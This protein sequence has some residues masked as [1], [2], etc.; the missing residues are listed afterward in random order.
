M[1]YISKY[2]KTTPTKSKAELIAEN[3]LRQ[4]Y[5]KEEQKKQEEPVE[6]KGGFSEFYGKYLSSPLQTA[7]AVANPVALWV[8]KA[9]GL[10]DKAED[11][12]RDIPVVN[13]IYS[14]I[15]DT[16][17][18]LFGG[19]LSSVE[20]IVDIGAGV[21]GGVGGAFSPEFQKKVKD[22]IATDFVGESVYAQNA[23]QNQASLINKLP[24]QGQNI[25]RG[26]AQGVGQVLPSVFTAGAAGAA[27][28][29]AKLAQGIGTATF[30]AGAAGKG[31]EEAFQEGAGYGQGLM[32][33]TAVGIVEGAIEKLTGGVAPKVFGKGLINKVV[34]KAI[35][36]NLGKIALNALGEGF[37]EALS[38]AI[39]PLL[40]RITYDKDAPLATKEQMLESAVIGA[41]TSIVSGATINR[42]DPVVEQAQELQKIN[43][44]ARE[45]WAEGKTDLTQYET[46]RTEAVAKYNKHSQEQITSAPYQYNEAVS[47][48][49]ENL[50]YQPTTQQ[51]TAEQQEA[52]KLFTQLSK[53]KG[54][55]FSDM[56]DGVNGAY[57]D[58]V[59]YINTKANAAQE[60][61]KHEL[62]HSAEGTKAYNKFA[63]YVLNTLADNSELAQNIKG[64]TLLESIKRTSE[65][66]Q[67]VMDGKG[68]TQQQREVLTEVVAQYSEKLLTDKT[69][70]ANLVRQDKSIAQKI[71][72][73]IR[74]KIAV[75]KGKTKAE[76][77]TIAFLRKAERLYVEALGET[78]QAKETKYS[79]SDKEKAEEHRQKAIEEFG[80]TP[81]FYDAGY[82]LPDG[83]MLNLSGE[84]G[85]H[86]GSRGEDHR[87]I[88]SIFEEG[89]LKGEY[90]S[91]GMVQFMN[92]GN[93]RIMPETPGI[94]ISLEV[95]PTIDQ[96]T[97]IQKFISD[98]GF[99][100]RYFNV[101]FSSKN[102]DNVDSIEYDGNVRASKVI[103]DIKAYFKTGKIPQQSEV[104]KFRYSLS[105]TDSQGR[106]LT[107][108]QQEFFKD[109]K[110]R[111]GNKLQTVWHFT[112]KGNDFTVFK[113]NALGLIFVSELPSAV[114][115]MNYNTSDQNTSDIKKI[116]N[117]ED[118]Y[119]EPRFELYGEDI[120]DILEDNVKE[121]FELLGNKVTPYYLNSKKP[122]MKFES[123]SEFADFMRFLVDQS[124][125]R[126]TLRTYNIST[127]D[128]DNVKSMTEED[129]LNT[130]DDLY[131]NLNGGQYDYR[132]T[133]P[134]VEW[135]KSK[136]YDAFL[137]YEDGYENSNYAFF[138]PNQ[139]KRVD[140]LNPTANEDIRY[141]LDKKY[142]KQDAEQVAEKAVDVIKIPQAFGIKDSKALKELIYKGLNQNQ[143]QQ[144]KVAFEVA[145]YI[146]EN[147][148]VFDGKEELLKNYDVNLKK[149]RSDIA[150]E[151]L[152]GYDKTGK[153]TSGWTAVQKLRQRIEDLKTQI[154]GVRDY[155]E[156][157][158]KLKNTVDLVANIGKFTPANTQ[159]ATSV[160][161]FIKAFTKIKTYYGN[162]SK[163]GRDIIRAYKGFYPELSG[164][165]ELE[166]DPIYIKISEISDGTGK[167]TLDELQ[168]VNTIL[169][170][171][172]ND[173]KN[174]QNVW[175]GEKKSTETDFAQEGIAD[176][177]ALQKESGSIFNRVIG[178]GVN[179]YNMWVMS[180]DVVFENYSSSAEGF[181][182]KAYQELF[183][184]AT[185]KQAAKQHEFSEIFKGFYQKNKKEV[186]TWRDKT[187]N[188][189]KNKIS[190]ETALSLY[191]T[192]QQEAG[193]RDLESGII[194]ISDPKAST[195]AKAMEKAKD[196]TFDITDLDG[197]YD[198]FNDAMKEY[199]RLGD[200]K[201]LNGAAQKTFA[202]T[203]EK[204][205]GVH[206]QLVKNYF[207]LRASSDQLYKSLDERAGD[208]TGLLT[209]VPSFTK[210]RKPNAKVKL[211]IEPYTDVISRHYRQL[212]HFAGW[213][214][215]LNTFNRVYNKSINGQSLR[216][217]LRKIDPNLE[218]Y[219]ETY[220]AD[221]Q[222]KR[223][224]LTGFDK[225]VSKIRGWGARAT[226]AFNPKVYL[227]QTVS[228]FAAHSM[229]ISY[230]DILKGG[231][232]AI[233]AKQSD[234]ELMYKYAPL[235]WARQ[236]EGYNIDVGLLKENQNIFGRI[237]KL[238][239][240]SL[241]LISKMDNRVI[242][243]VWQACLEHTKKDYTL[244]SDEHYK[245]AGKLLESTMIRT[246]ANYHPTFRAAAL[247][248]RN[249][250]AQFSTM[251]IS[252]PLKQ[253]GQMVAAVRAIQKAK[254]AQKNAK[255]ESERTKATQQLKD[256]SSRARHAATAL[257]VQA[258]LIVM[259]N[260]LFRKFLGKDDEEFLK[261][262]GNDFADNFIGMFPV[263]RDLYGLYQG[264]DLSNMYYTGLT[265]IFNAFDGLLDMG[266]NP[267]KALRGF[268]LGMSQFF[269]M[270]LKNVERY[271][272]AL[273]DKFNPDTSYKYNDIF[274]K[275]S[276]SKDLKKAIEK[277]DDKK[278]D[279]IIELM[280]NDKGLGTD[281]KTR[282]ELI[283][284]YASGENVLPT[285]ISDTVNG[286][287][288]TPSQK[289]QI[290]DIYSK[291][292]ITKL[293]SMSEYTKMTAAQ[294]AKAIRTIYSLQKD[295]A[296]ARV[297]GIEMSSRAL[298]TE[299]VDPS[300]IAYVLAMISNMGDNKKVK[301]QQLINRLNIP[302][303]Q[304][305]ML[306]GLAGYKNKNGANIVKALINKLDLS[307]AE[308]EK[309][310]Q[311]SGY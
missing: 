166:T 264:Y 30:M 284:L 146:I 305:Y 26:V 128:I 215:P 172:R 208:M 65:L 299:A 17:A 258:V 182:N 259:I 262:V 129:I 291:A 185:R 307:K 27:G 158:S 20:G 286:Q 282:A 50:V 246:Q 3:R 33:G 212:A 255:T 82:I 119:A 90:Q 287:E 265:N 184:E 175:W 5:K 45:A 190:V 67:K 219:I 275:Q 28:A 46:R 127:N 225:L 253:Y 111:S 123:D 44:E 41:L 240:A 227:N 112:K 37:E 161:A 220:I 309:L 207:P 97:I 191:A 285:A 201:F 156:A 229:G 114:L 278:A 178:R 11:K 297:L 245:A 270:P 138:N 78:A 200:K 303:T 243:G 159:L 107:K 24:Q 249:A 199:L 83:E 140:N 234:F 168:A 8:G 38:E 144:S 279:T 101:D 18:N 16:Q 236:Q 198:Q 214:V 35:K 231:T 126:E 205:Y 288:L 68:L 108:E 186:E 142:T 304:K 230:F 74:D 77:D 84:K 124:L 196:I 268:A 1:A 251:F 94:D 302:A 195:L 71:L 40:K 66:Y 15:G 150:R 12:I 25:V 261:S 155:H 218:N 48:G 14:T 42:V 135:V 257:S 206:A 148:V 149:V 145:D 34:G 263:V 289:K 308:K 235:T 39:N 216:A 63:K 310:Y 130:F 306:M 210:S 232:R 85:K 180:P 164:E 49:V 10:L 106:K 292:D 177:Q 19:T 211:V 120:T 301:I 87:I 113:P 248:E 110:I 23:I 174:Y 52:K 163:N 197:L 217:E 269:G 115:S 60:I 76:K 189:G 271:T 80:Y 132:E 204:R 266:E 203:Y 51:L 152:Q 7:L 165:I 137:V 53:D 179:K 241:A 293:I 276:Y 272:V 267:A 242:M 147:T 131:Y 4:Q 2:K 134:F 9:T 121:E 92:E 233:T 300:L 187:V 295:K 21:V 6:S 57:K 13:D 228:L 96:Y 202:E 141:S 260:Q 280:L 169:S 73:W 29:S 224:T 109:S 226:L 277:G 86:F 56:E 59:V 55:V 254:Q 117:P 105:D 81:Y 273:I 170:K 116:I 181:M 221:I 162:I 188:L 274:Y 281:D 151:V 36:S 91:E 54:L 290:S 171:F 252:E 194:S 157:E 237:D 192:A 247:R 95:E 223:P 160:S 238:T 143:D 89:E 153:H 99:R 250:I 98:Y 43:Q 61:I 244:Y 193:L 183:V 296:I 58:G 22:F 173:I 176:V 294:K 104:D 213:A 125:D 122:F 154:R 298:F 209:V 93:L 64:E 136:K 69:Q 79:L 100:K 88:Q 283:E 62:A 239:E 70:I 118:P 139:L 103:N 256:A 167:L 102:G 222:G 32:Y 31:T 133:A 72:D 75:L 311:A 47:P